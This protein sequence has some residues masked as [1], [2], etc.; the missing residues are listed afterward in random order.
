MDKLDAA[1][2]ANKNIVDAIRGIP[3]GIAGFQINSDGN[4]YVVYSSKKPVTGRFP[5]PAD[6]PQWIPLKKIL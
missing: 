3:V 5:F 4:T 6:L 1:V 2:Q